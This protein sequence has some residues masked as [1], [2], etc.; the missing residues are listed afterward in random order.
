MLFILVTL[1]RQW[2]TCSQSFETLADYS[3]MRERNQR[4]HSPLWKTW[5]GGFLISER[6]TLFFP[7]LF[8]LIKIRLQVNFPQT[9]QNWEKLHI[10]QNIYVNYILT[11]GMIHLLLLKPARTFILTSTIWQ[12]Q[13]LVAQGHLQW[14]D[15]VK[16]SICTI[17]KEKLKLGPWN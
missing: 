13:H 1:E 11:R 16:A 17:T 4:Q 3:Y 8:L 10:G 12:G 5:V 15:V 9:T 7:N 14:R 2:K 6:I